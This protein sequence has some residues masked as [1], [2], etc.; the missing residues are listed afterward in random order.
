M[1][2]RKKTGVSIPFFLFSPEETF[3]K[4]FFVGSFL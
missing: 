2:A 4:E 3:L 1:E